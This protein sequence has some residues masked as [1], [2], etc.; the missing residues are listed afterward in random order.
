MNIPTGL[1]LIKFIYSKFPECIE[2]GFK[3]GV[4]WDYVLIKVVNRYHKLEHKNRYYLK[5]D[6]TDYSIIH[7]LARGN[8]YKVAE[9]LNI[10]LRVDKVTKRN[11]RRELKDWK[12]RYDNE[13]LRA[14]NYL[15]YP[16]LLGEFIQIVETA[17][18]LRS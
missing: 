16:E 5:E 15:K 10:D 12:E 7:N 3:F 14:D 2:G 4:K 17:P 13:C 1:D 11:V 9:L 8:C 6:N 18:K